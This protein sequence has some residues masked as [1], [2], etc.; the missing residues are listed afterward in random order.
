LAIANTL[1]ASILSLFFHWVLLLRRVCLGFWH[2][3]QRKKKEVWDWGWG[4]IKTQLE[5]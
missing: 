5:F 1:K 2:D 3:E 4:V